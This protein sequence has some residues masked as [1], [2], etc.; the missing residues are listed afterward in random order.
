MALCFRVCVCVCVCVCMLSMCACKGICRLSDGSV[1]F[2]DAGNNSIRVIYFATSSTQPA[3]VSAGIH[4]ARCFCVCVCVCV[5]ACI[6]TAVSVGIHCASPA[7]LRAC[8]AYVLK[9]GYT[10]PAP[11]LRSCRSCHRRSLRRCHA[12]HEA[13]KSSPA[14]PAVFSLSLAFSRCPCFLCRCRC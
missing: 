6:Y 1:V 8:V 9:S 14:V 5:Y 3:A 7:A 4:C 11:R 13:R 12:E 10:D 2:A